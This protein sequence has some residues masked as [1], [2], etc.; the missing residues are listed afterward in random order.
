MA[1]KWWNWD[2]EYSQ[3]VW[4]ESAHHVL[5]ISATVVPQSVCE[6]KKGDSSGSRH[7]RFTWKTDICKFIK[8][9]NLF[10]TWIISNPILRQPYQVQR[11]E[12]H[13]AH[14]HKAC[15]LVSL[16]MTRHSAIGTQWK[17]SQ[18]CPDRRNK[19]FSK[20]ETDGTS[21]YVL[22]H[23][24]TFQMRQVLKIHLV[25]HQDLSRSELMTTVQAS[26]TILSLRIHTFL[27]TT[28]APVPFGELKCLMVSAEALTDQLGLRKALLCLTSSL[29][30]VSWVLTYSV[31]NIMC[32]HCR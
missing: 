3:V 12:T 17:V 4:L 32:S 7:L 20:H 27:R 25:F 23:F 2:L 8:L 19:E 6:Q 31:Y 5:T 22:M 30:G 18:L 15:C 26:E 28:D 14:V 21:G 13:I 10:S 11:V 29:G 24:S 9:Y 16:E 1:P